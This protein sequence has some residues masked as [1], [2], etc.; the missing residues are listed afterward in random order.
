MTRTEQNPFEILSRIPD[1]EPDLGKMEDA[2]RRS[3]EAFAEQ[4][5][6]AKLTS[7]SN[8]WQK[9]RLWLADHANRIIPTTAGACAVAVA[10]VVVVPQLRG[11]AAPPAPSMEQAPVEQVPTS[12]AREKSAPLADQAE[13]SQSRMGVRPA[14]VPQ[15]VSPDQQPVLERYD[16]GSLHLGVINT[17][18]TTAIYLIEGNIQR[19]LEISRKE[20][21]VKGVITDALLHQGNTGAPQLLLI[22]FRLGAVEGWRVFVKSGAGFAFSKELTAIAGQAETRDAAIHSLERAQ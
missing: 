16:F 4:R 10:L 3:S 17:A 7:H 13:Q 14:P 8:P 2:A 22:R 6:R 9:V 19:Q 18:Q 21:D 1:P 20:A 11:P 15:K 5:S 12:V